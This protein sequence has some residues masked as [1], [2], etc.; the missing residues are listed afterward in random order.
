[1]NFDRSNSSRTPAAIFRS[2]LTSSRSIWRSHRPRR[3]SLRGS[4]GA[5]VKGG[6]PRDATISGYIRSDIS[7]WQ[8]PTEFHMLARMAETTSERSRAKRANGRRA[9]GP[10]L[11]SGNRL[12]RHFG[13]ARSHVETLAQQG[14]IER[15]AQNLFDQ[16]VSRRPG[17]AVS[18]HVRSADVR[19]IAAR[20][21]S[22]HSAPAPNARRSRPDVRGRGSAGKVRFRSDANRHVARGNASPI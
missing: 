3:R 1:M 18:A 11:V 7:R 22:T 19:N 6:G 21:T 2:S 20:S 12:A 14:V 13:V 15:N 17:F 9:L 4:R 8:R 16:D 5:H 10:V